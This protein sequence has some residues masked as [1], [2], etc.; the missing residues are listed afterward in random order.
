MLHSLDEI[1]WAVNPQNDTLEQ[2][3]SYIGQY[4]QE[5]FQMTG[6]KCEMDLPTRLPRHS[7]SSQTR[8]HLFLAVRE[9]CTNMLKHSAAT[10]CK[11]SMACSDA[12]LE[13]VI[14]DNGSGFVRPALA[15]GAHDPA[16]GSGNGLRNL[17]Q[18]MADIGGHCAVESAP[19]RGT[20]VRFTL[21]L[22]PRS[23]KELIT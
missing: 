4:V 6:I 5:Y 14:S 22:N 15:G 10:R 11:V 20:T 19:G 13:I 8:H 16:A 21:P 12:N 23:A 17:S 7:L 3:A 2:L 9:A 1:V 18:R